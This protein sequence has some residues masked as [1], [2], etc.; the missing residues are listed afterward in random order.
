[1]TCIDCLDRT[2]CAQKIIALRVLNQNQLPS[3]GLDKNRYSVFN[4][5]FRQMW[6]E[7]G[8]KLSII[9]AGTA[10]MGTESALKEASKSIFRTEIGR[11]HV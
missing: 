9:Y 8:D 11:A 4:S 10:A 6:I 5:T 3:L 1:M 2:N 7:N